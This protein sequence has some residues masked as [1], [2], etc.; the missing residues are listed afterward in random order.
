MLSLGVRR[1]VPGTSRAVDGDAR[2]ELEA[3]PHAPGGLRRRPAD[4]SRQYGPTSA[5]ICQAQI[6]SSSLLIDHR[7]KTPIGPPVRPPGQPAIVTT[8]STRSSAAS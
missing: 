4:S 8:R 3:D 2:V 7:P 6:G 1:A 5:S